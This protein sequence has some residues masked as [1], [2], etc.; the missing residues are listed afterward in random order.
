MI[1]LRFETLDG[2]SKRKTFKTLKGAQ[3]FTWNWVG[4][5]AELGSYYAISA[6]GVVKVRVEGGSGCTLLQLFDR[7]PV[8]PQE[9]LEEKFTAIRRG[10][11]RYKLYCGKVCPM[12]FFAVA[13]ETYDTATGCHRDGWALRGSGDYERWFDSDT[14]YHTLQAALKAARAIVT[15]YRKYCSEEAAAEQFAENAW[16]RHA[17]M[18]TMQS[19]AE[20]DYERAREAAFG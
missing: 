18:G 5:D 7:E 12:N 4:K 1:K 15:D 6:D 14:H 2:I 8:K 17:E 16:L 9:Q 13:Y 20:E 11:D 10:V 3:K 19:Q